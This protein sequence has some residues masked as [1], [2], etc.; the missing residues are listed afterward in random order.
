MPRIAPSSTPVPGA[1]RTWNSVPPAKSMPSRMPRS[2][3]AA[4]DATSIPME[5]AAQMRRLP[6]KSMWVPGGTSSMDTPPPV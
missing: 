1:N 5:S 4:I 3:T 6:M 2:G